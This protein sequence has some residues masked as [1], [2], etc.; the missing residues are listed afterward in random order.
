MIAS[1][2]SSNGRDRHCISRP[3]RSSSGRIRE[4]VRHR[5]DECTKTSKT[6]QVAMISHPDVPHRRWRRRLQSADTRDLVADDPRQN[7]DPDALPAHATLQVV[8]AEA[9]PLHLPLGPAAHLIAEQKL[10]AFCRDMDALPCVATKLPEKDAPLEEI[11]VR[12][13]EMV[14]AT[15]QFDVTGHPAMSI[16]CGLVDGLPVGMMLVA[17]DYNEPVFYQAASAFEADGDWR[18][19]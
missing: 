18:T 8:D 16:P 9:P 3:C 6:S 7:R 14:G 2:D 19:F 1:E 10:A 15:C 4:M 12:A 13:F 17:K 11:I 5:R